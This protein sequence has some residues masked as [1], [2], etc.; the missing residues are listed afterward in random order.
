[1]EEAA[2]IPD[3][4]VTAFYTLFNQLG[5]PI[6]SSFPTPVAPPLATVPILIYG[7]GSTAGLYAIQLLHLAG[8]KKVIATASKKHHDYLRSL[9][10]SDTFDY[11]S[12]S[13]VED[14]A[15][16]IG[17]DG[18]A[19]LALDCVSAETTLA[20]VGKIVSPLG[21]V[22][23]LLPIKEGNSVTGG[24]DQEMLWEVPN[25][26]NPFPKETEIIYVRTFTYLQVYILSITRQPRTNFATYRTKT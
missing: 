9:G 11:N 2:T 8:Y 15:S 21:K 6:P 26:K 25:D 16:A 14:I 13:L 3:N 10:A 22:A 18:K 7:A 19:L 4:F 5:L 12:S 23:I 1:M 20:L 17:G 24:Q